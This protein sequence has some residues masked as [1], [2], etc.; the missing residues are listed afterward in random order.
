VLQAEILVLRRSSAHH[1]GD[2][3]MR[4]PVEAVELAAQI[5]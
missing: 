3:L 1:Q 4:C 5:N 2:Q